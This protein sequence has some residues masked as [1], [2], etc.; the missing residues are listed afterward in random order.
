MKLKK[1][2]TMVIPIVR[3]KLDLF[4][5]TNRDL[6][7][8]DIGPVI[9]IYYSKT[10]LYVG[11]TIGFKDRHLKHSSEKEFKNHR[12][13]GVVIL[14]GEHVDLNAQNDLEGQLISYFQADKDVYKRQSLRG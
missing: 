12:Y 5:C 2:K 11:Q 9:Y 4:G 1:Y 7:I 6:K 8:L 13:E 3:K 10:R 14:F